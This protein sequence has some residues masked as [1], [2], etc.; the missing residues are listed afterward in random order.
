MGTA[1]VRVM[2]VGQIETESG[3]QQCQRMIKR[4]A[5]NEA[6]FIASRP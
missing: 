2:S 1:V 6:G 4:R 5:E 3:K